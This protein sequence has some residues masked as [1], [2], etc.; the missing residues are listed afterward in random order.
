MKTK[1]FF[2]PITVVANE[3]YRFIHF[4]T[5]TIQCEI[6]HKQFF[7]QKGHMQ[8]ENDS[9]HSLTQKQIKQQAKIWSYLYSRRIYY[10]YESSSKKRENV[11]VLINWLNEDFFYLKNLSSTIEVKIYASSLKISNIEVIKIHL[12]LYFIKLPSV[13]LNSK[14][15]KLLIKKQK[16][17]TPINFPKIVLN[18]GISCKTYL[19]ISKKAN[20]HFISMN[21]ILKMYKPFYESV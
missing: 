21:L 16:E 4:C 14:N 2:I 9:A 12:V 6:G 8:D 18:T 15:I 20:L 10:C 5:S 17:K 7:N 13:K 11:L 1:L 3:K 19:K